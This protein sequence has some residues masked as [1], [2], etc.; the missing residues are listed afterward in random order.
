[1]YVFSV[2]V[3]KCGR[4][5]GASDGTGGGERTPYLSVIMSGRAGGLRVVVDW[6]L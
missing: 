5:E 4:G 6:T 2:S 3:S 1:M